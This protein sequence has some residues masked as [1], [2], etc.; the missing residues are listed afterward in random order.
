MIETA[1]A[2][3]GFDQF[4]QHIDSVLQAVV[5][6]NAVSFELEHARCATWKRGRF[7]MR[8]WPTQVGVVVMIE[9][10]Q[11]Y[12]D[13]FLESRLPQAAESLGQRFAALLSG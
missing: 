4:A 7:R 12:R 2:I 11:S 13:D 9:L 5:E 10:D 6:S 1:G 3:E 8:L